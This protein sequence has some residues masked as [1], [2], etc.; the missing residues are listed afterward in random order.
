M[1]EDILSIHFFS[2]AW[3]SPT[4]LP[5]QPNQSQTKTLKKWPS[6]DNPNLTRIYKRWDV[7]MKNSHN[8]YYSGIENLL[9]LIYPKKK[10]KS[11]S[12]YHL[13]IILFSMVQPNESYLAWYG[14]M[15]PTLDNRINKAKLI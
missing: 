12:S 15:N 11:S 14:Q 2:Y 4:V 9:P 13:T 3:P 8:Q 1:F 5:D 7:A 6:K 10:E